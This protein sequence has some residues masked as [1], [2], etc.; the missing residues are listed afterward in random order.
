MREQPACQNAKI[1]LKSLVGSGLQVEIIFRMALGLSKRTVW[2]GF[3]ILLERFG[4]PA[5]V[6]SRA[7]DRQHRAIKEWLSL[8]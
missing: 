7:R 6:T 1:F 4:K 3:S 8:D 5:S 2:A